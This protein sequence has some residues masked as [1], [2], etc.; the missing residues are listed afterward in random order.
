[1]AT[2]DGSTATSRLYFSAFNSDIFITSPLPTNGLLINPLNNIT[3]A[4]VEGEASL[5]SDCTSV[6]TL[7][8]GGYGRIVIN[9]TAVTSGMELLTDS[10]VL[11]TW[12]P[13]EVCSYYIHLLYYS[14]IHM[15]MFVDNN[16]CCA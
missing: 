6:S 16:I 4:L 10:I 1:M 11:Y 9:M 3:C 2:I 14:Y 8:N 7:P 15:S 5:S 13:T 12:T